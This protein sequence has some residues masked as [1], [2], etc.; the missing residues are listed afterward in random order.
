MK[1]LA[2]KASFFISLSKNPC[3]HVRKTGV[4]VLKME[5]RE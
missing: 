3:F 5:N 4:L 2:E 1:K